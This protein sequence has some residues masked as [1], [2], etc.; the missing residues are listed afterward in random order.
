C[1]VL[2]SLIL[3]FTMIPLMAGRYLREEEIKPGASDR[4]LGWLRTRYETG[5]TWALGNTAL[6]LIATVLMLGIGVFIYSQLG[7]GFLPTMDEGSFVLDY[8]MPAGTSL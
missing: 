2:V 4:L 8:W 6:V 5:I 7:S 1:A 3:A